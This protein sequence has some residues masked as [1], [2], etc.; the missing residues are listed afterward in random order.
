MQWM[1]AGTPAL[2]PV[3]M[4]PPVPKIDLGPSQAHQFTCAE[5]MPISKQNCS[6][7]SGTVPTSAAR[8]FDE[9]IYLSL[10]QILTRPVVGVGP[11]PRECS[12]YRGRHILCRC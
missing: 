2:R 8:R 6:T 10:Y 12:V 5:P 1:H 3:D 9:P 11:T 7:I 4:Q